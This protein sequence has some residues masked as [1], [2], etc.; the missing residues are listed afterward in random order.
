[1][2]AGFEVGKMAI[3]AVFAAFLT[4][5]DA[6]MLHKSSKYTHLQ[7]VLYK[8]GFTEHFTDIFCYWNLHVSQ[9]TQK[10]ILH[11]WNQ[12]VVALN[13]QQTKHV[14]LFLVCDLCFPVDF[15]SA[16]TFPLNLLPDDLIKSLYYPRSAAGLACQ[17]SLYYHSALEWV[18]LSFMNLNCW[19]H[20]TT[21]V[22][23]ACASECRCVGLVLWM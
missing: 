13:R 9:I 3:F 16:D 8:N 23:F 15:Q 21:A 20:V 1:M 14:Y 11:D 2:E 5:F 4:K 18:L 7:H 6:S 17:G 12:G 10:T 22:K 19:N